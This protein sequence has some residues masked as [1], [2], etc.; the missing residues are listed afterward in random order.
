MCVRLFLFFLIGVG[1]CLTSSVLAQPASLLKDLQAH[2][3]WYSYSEQQFLPFVPEVGT[4]PREIH[5]RVLAA[6][7]PKDYFNVQLDSGT[8]VFLN[9]QFLRVHPNSGWWSVRCDSLSRETL[10]TLSRPEGFVKL[11]QAGF[12]TQ[13]RRV[14]QRSERPLFERFEAPSF[15]PKRKP[16]DVHTSL[17]FMLLAAWLL[18]VG[19]RSTGHTFFYKS[20]LSDILLL[21]Q[22]LLQTK[23]VSLLQQ[24]GFFGM[25]FTVGALALL[26]LLYSQEGALQT[27]SSLLLGLLFRALSTLVIWISLKII[28]LHF[29]NW[30]FFGRRT[31]TQPHILV[32]RETDHPWLMLLFVLSIF[33]AGASG[34]IQALALEALQVIVPVGLILGAAFRSFLLVRSFEFRN[35]LVIAY[36]CATE[37]LPLLLVF[38][39]WGE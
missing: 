9:N 4:P 20:Q 17:R 8:K 37:I 27:Q 19:L 3:M 13:P 15:L 2:W 12:S 18:L 33:G 21:P 39:F 35:L 36:L 25:Y 11:P 10:F 31:V 38:S 1:G 24:T 6:H 23:N 14:F 29:A 7:Y 5:L 30:L 32:W 22:R 16:V 28:M 34:N 26:L